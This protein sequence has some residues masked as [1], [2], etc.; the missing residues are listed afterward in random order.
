MFSLNAK[1]FFKGL[2]VAI[3]AGVVT[4]LLQ[5]IGIPGFSVNS[6]QWG[7]ILRV[8]IEAGLAYI[9]K[10]YLSNNQGQFAGIGPKN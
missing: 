9:A 7:E 3:L 1:D 4:W 2:L 10:N 6:I 8:A 5:V